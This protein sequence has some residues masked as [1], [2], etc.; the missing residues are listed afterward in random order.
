MS[1]HAANFSRTLDGLVIGEIKDRELVVLRYHLQSEVSPGGGYMLAECIAV[2]A[3]GR[4]R[5][6][7]Q[8]FAGIYRRGSQ[9]TF[10]DLLRSFPGAFHE[11]CP[12]LQKT[13]TPV[14]NK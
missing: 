12:P 2:A 5:N 3:G 10:N 4:V 8:Q 6:G 14:W 11:F 7:R 13:N 9:R 1:G